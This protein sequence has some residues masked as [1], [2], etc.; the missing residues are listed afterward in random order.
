MLSRY[1]FIFQLELLQIIYA[2]KL[3][4]F[5]NTQIVTINKFSIVDKWSKVENQVFHGHSVYCI[6][7]LGA[8]S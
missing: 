7:F 2:R 1:F 5:G 3:K 8:S 6:L 4:R